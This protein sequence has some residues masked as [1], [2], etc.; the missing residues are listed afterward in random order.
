MKKKIAVLSAIFVLL[1]VLGL[2]YNL[3]PGK[4]LGGDFWKQK[5][6][7]FVRWGDS[8]RQNGD[9]FELNIGGATRTAK[10]TE[11]GEKYRVD[12][13]DG[14]AVEMEY[15]TAGFSIQIGSMSFIGDAEYIL[16]DMDAA[17]LRFGKV[18]DEVREP[19]YDENGYAVGESFY[20]VTESGESVGWQEIWYDNPDWSSPEPKTILLQEGVRLKYDDFNRNLFVN[21]DGEYLM[22]AQ[23]VPMLHWSG[24]TWYGRSSV[25][26]HLINIA[27]GEISRRGHIAG[28]LLYA[29]IY[30]LGAVNFLWPQELAFLGKRWQFKE[31]PE[32]S[33]EGLFMAKLG[34]II[35][36]VMGVVVMFIGVQ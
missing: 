4:F 16:T 27:H 25:A 20:R 28:V 12:F 5:D 9:E 18:V 8:I 14:W 35:I 29:F 11:S 32:L 21:E 24:S 33:D 22:N 30:L 1:L 17:N 15:R 26:G 10:L 23:D 31:E 19:F 6:G 13:S 2:W 3:T 7:A 34:S 36:M